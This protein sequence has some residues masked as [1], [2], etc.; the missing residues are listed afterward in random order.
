MRD[1]VIVITG[2]SSGFGEL[3]ARNC[4]AAGARVVLA[5]RSAD[6]IEALAHELGGETRALAMPTDVTRDA[7]AARLIDASL[8]RF[9]RI[10]ALVNNAGFGVLDAVADAK[11]SDLQEMMDVN[12]YGAIRCTQAALPHM[13]ARRRGQIVMM[14]SIAGLVT[15]RNMAFYSG[16]K[17][18][19]VGITRTL[20]LE[21]QGSGVRCALICPGVAQTGFQQRAVESKYARITRLTSVT[22]EAVARATQRAIA[23]GAHGEIVLPWY[24][25]LLALGAHALPG[26]ARAIM[27]IVG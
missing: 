27:R 9:G 2:A 20:M 4:A 11:L 24:G 25:R 13:R 12:V 18:A 10:D 22:P 6:R 8:R 1:S 7:D 21:L 15:S 19:L 5:A 14:A 23:R 3:I 17:H 26:V 16:T